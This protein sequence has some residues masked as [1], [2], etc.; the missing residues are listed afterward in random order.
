MERAMC[1]VQLEN[2]KKSKDLVLMLALNETAD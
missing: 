2:R 1:G